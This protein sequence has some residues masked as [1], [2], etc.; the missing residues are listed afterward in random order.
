MRFAIYQRDHYRCQK[1]G[2]Q[3]NDLEVDHIVPIA[4]GG[5]ST[6]DN[7]QTLCHRCNSAKGSNLY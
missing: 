1:C 2:R 6:Y 5:K 7:L 4:K 3:T